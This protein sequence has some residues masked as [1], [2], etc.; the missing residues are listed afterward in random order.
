MQ[1]HSHEEI[2]CIPVFHHGVLTEYEINER[3]EGQEGGN[4]RAKGQTECR[5]AK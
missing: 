4:L 5:H 3:S 1:P 2:A